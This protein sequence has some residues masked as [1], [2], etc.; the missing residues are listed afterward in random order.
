M[1]CAM[2][3]MGNEMYD[4]PNM[5]PVGRSGNDVRILTKEDMI[6]L[7]EGADLMLLPGR[8]ALV[9]Q[10]GKIEKIA[11]SLYA[12][13]AMLPMGYTRTYLTPP[14]HVNFNGEEGGI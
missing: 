9:G 6:E 7:P 12:V 4:A 3:A 2:Y 8:S 1:L 11:S 5:A 14:D 13:A 10:K